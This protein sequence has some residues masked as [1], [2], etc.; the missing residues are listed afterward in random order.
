MDAFK[1]ELRKRDEW[2]VYDSI[3]YH[4]ELIEY[5]LERLIEYF[6]GNDPMNEKDVYIFA[7]FV[8]AQ[9]DKLIGIAQELDNEYES[10]V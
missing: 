7:S 2:G 6:N 5:P 10:S 8:S 9:V 3:N 1:Q 4:Y